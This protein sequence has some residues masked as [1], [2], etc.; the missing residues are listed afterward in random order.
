ML[1]TFGPSVCRHLEIIFK[2]IWKSETFV[3]EQKK[4]EDDQVHKKIK[5]NL[6]NY[7]PISLLSI[8][9][10]ASLHPTERLFKPNFAL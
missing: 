3:Q 2:H 1:K 5:N 10:P 4:T 7:R 6:A 8:Y 9:L